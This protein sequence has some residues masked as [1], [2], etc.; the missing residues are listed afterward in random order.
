MRTKLKSW[1]KLASGVALTLMLAPAI[2]SA[3]AQGQP[4]AGKTVRFAQS[5]SLGA[6]YV[7][8]YILLAAL[9]KLGYKTTVKNLGIATFFQAAAQGDLDVSSDINWPQREPAFK[10]VEQQLTLVGDG[11]IIG[12]GINGYVIDKKTADAHK[13]T[14]FEQLKDPKIAALFDTDGDGKA[15]LHNCDPGWSCGDVVDFQIEKFG[16][17]DTVRSVRAKYEALMADVFAR[18]RRGEPVLYYTWS[19]SW[20]VDGLVPGKDVVWLPIPYDALPSGVSNSGG[21]LVKGVVGCAGGQDP[22][23]MT[24]GSWNWRTVASRKFVQ[25][26]PS[27]KKLFEVA[28]WPIET[29]AS[30]EGAINKGAKNNRDIKKVADTW[31]EQNQK[32]F[33]GWV[34]E[35]AAASRPSN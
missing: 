1:T 21:H 13:I 20:V 25:E 24:V 10:Q 7:Q 33:D 8:D 3:F 14:N 2:P 18:A 11:S 34:A 35:A 31:I 27:A 4:G 17:T 23:R 9:E 32:V 6:N 30:W 5:D 15:N 22:C 28:K 16:L 19:P 12:G 29:W 26:N